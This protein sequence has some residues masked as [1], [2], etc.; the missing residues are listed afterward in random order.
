MPTGTHASE[1]ERSQTCIQVTMLPLANCAISLRDPRNTRT[2]PANWQVDIFTFQHL[3]KPRGGRKRVVKEF[4]TGSLPPS[5]ALVL[6]H[7]FLS[8]SLFPR[9]QLPR[10]WNRLRSP[11]NGSF[12]NPGVCPQAVPSF[13][14]PTPTVLFMALAP[15][16]AQAKYRKPRSSV[17]LCSQTLRKR[18]LRRLSLKDLARQGLISFTKHKRPISSE[19][20]EVLQQISWVW[21][22]QKVFQIWHV[23][24]PFST[25]E[26]EAVKTNARW[27]PVT[28]SSKQQQAGWSTSSQARERRKISPPSSA[29]DFTHSVFHRCEFSDWNTFLSSQVFEQFVGIYEPNAPSFRVFDP[30]GVTRVNSQDSLSNFVQSQWK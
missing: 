21:M 22:L 29:T 12:Q 25:S 28:F 10:A 17:F 20:L 8:L 19:D 14:S 15:F 4:L 18:L 30:R 11:A 1:N 3:I 5:L 9:P 23:L 16:S 24:T 2:F 13:P 27:N 6:P 26:R 7:F